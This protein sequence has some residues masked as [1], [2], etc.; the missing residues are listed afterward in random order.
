[1][2]ELQ[3]ILMYFIVTKNITRLI[4]CDTTVTD[5]KNKF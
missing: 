3:N 4:V 5:I 1:M 2:Y